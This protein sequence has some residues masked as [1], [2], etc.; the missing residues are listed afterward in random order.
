MAERSNGSTTIAI[1]AIFISVTTAVATAYF[2]H[3]QNRTSI[4]PVL[5]FIYDQQG[6]E[7]RN[8]GSGPALD[9]IVSHTNHGSDQWL[10]PTRV[11]PLEG[12]GGKLRLPWVGDNPEKIVAFYRDAHGRSYVSRVQ[13]DKTIVSYEETKP[14]WDIKEEKRVWEREQSERR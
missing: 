4:L 6:W 3:L 11:Y 8:V 9:P 2:S 5:V 10:K 12:N 14:L 1:V 13:D 7:L